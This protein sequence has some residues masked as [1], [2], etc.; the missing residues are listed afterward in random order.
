MLQ[1]LYLDQVARR[2]GVPKFR[3]GDSMSRWIERFS[4]QADSI[5]LTSA[6]KAHYIGEYLPPKISN[7]LLLAVPT[8]DCDAIVKALT[9]TFDRGP[10]VDY[11]QRWRAFKALRQ[12]SCPLRQFRIDFET[13]LNQFPIDR[14][15]K[16]EDALDIFFDA[17][18]SRPRQ[19]LEPTL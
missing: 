15:L 5:G 6:Q 11:Q 8:Q 12:G 14:P 19:L 9:A 13:A 17:I 1:A 18:N 3:Q 10:A 2:L 16:P 4:Q 7:W